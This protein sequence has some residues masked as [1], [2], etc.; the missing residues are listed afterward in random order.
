MR[1]MQGHIIE[2]TMSNL[3]CF[4]DGTWLTPRLNNCGVAGV[5]RQY[6]MDRLMPSLEQPVCEAELTLENLAGMDEIFLCNSV[7]GIWPVIQLRAAARGAGSGSQ[8]RLQRSFPALYHRTLH[9]S[10]FK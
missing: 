10:T 9:V 6:L 5:M 1:D 2:G 4:R 3:F 8:V 7:A